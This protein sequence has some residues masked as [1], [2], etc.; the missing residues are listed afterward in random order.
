MNLGLAATTST[1]GFDLYMWDCATAYESRTL[2]AYMIAN[3][4]CAS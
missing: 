1:T 2:Y 4:V 3:D